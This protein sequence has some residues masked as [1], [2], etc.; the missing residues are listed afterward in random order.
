MYLEYCC[1]DYSI[2][3]VETTNNV[4]MAIKHGIR[5]IFLLPYSVAYQAKND[6]INQSVKFGSVIDFPYGLSDQKSRNSMVENLV[7]SNKISML[8]IMIPTKIITNR[9]YEKFRD[10]I[11]SSL[12][13]CASANIKIRYILEYRVYSH[14]VLAKICQILKTFNIDTVLPSSGMMLDDIH[15]NLIACKFLQT[16]TQINTICNANIY[17]DQHVKYIKNSQIFGARIHNTFSLD[18]FKI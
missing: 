15:D 11:K 18:L 4:S 3:E 13:I 5:N 16:K 9:K 2:N 1:Y 17:L 7:K 12:D 8:D 10:D 14:D 6:L